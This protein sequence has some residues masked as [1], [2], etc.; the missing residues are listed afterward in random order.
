M[1]LPV[2]FYIIAQYVVWAQLQFPNPGF[3][4]PVPSSFQPTQAFSD[5]YVKNQGQQSPGQILEQFFNPTQVKPN[6]ISAFN[7]PFDSLSNVRTFNQ[8][9]VPAFKKNSLQNAIEHLYERVNAI[10]SQSH[11][12]IENSSTLLDETAL[13][14]TNMARKV[15]AT[16]VSYIANRINQYNETIRHCIRDHGSKYGEIIPAARD[17][18][19]EC[20]R[21]KKNEGFAIIDEARVNIVDVINGAQNFSSSIQQCS[22]LDQ[23]TQINLG[24]YTYAVLNI[25]SATV[26][27]PLEM[28]KRYSEIDRAVSTTRAGIIECATIITETAS[29]QSVNA[30]KTIADCLRKYSM[31]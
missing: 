16:S 23:Q 14:I 2:L 10:S 1:K 17:E 21:D 3:E 26:L 15:T 19:V 13:S 31:I 9:A 24:C 7:Q 8:L 4:L 18:A 29:V 27:L 30:T 22:S 20:V 25:R 6:P 5:S 11:E 12:R 28:A